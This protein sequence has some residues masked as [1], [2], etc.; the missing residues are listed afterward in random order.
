[1]PIDF[2]EI[3]NWRQFEDLVCDL[4]E[5]EG[6]H[7]EERAGI[8][9]DEGRDILAVGYFTNSL[10][11][12]ER[13]YLVSCKHWKGPVP[14]SEVTDIKDKMIQHEANGYLLVTYDIRSGLQHKIDG[15]KRELTIKYWLKRDIENLLIIHKDVFKK[16]LPK[17]YTQFFG[18]EGLIPESELIEL[19]NKKYGRNPNTDELI[20]WRKDTL[21]YSLTNLHEI[22][23]ILD[24]KDVL[25]S[26]NEM[27]E[28]LLAR[29]VDPMGHLTWGYLLH[30]SK[31]EETK[32][33][34]EYNIRHLVEFLNRARLIYTAHGLPRTEIHFESITQSFFQW[35][36]YHILWSKGILRVDPKAFPPY[37]EMESPQDNV[38]A[39]QWSLGIQLLNKKVIV[40]DVSRDNFF[41]VFLLVRAN[42][43]KPY[44]IKYGYS[45]GQPKKVRDA[46]IDYAEFFLGAEFALNAHPPQTLETNFENDLN[47]LYNVKVSSVLSLHFRVRGK[48]K[49]SRI[50]LAEAP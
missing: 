39:I 36:P 30:V 24:D 12:M 41:E 42:D 3:E 4:L 26:L 48:A 29:K 11:R 18:L 45:A 13:R 37:I 27:Y 10:E 21:N 31:T 50:L 43:G 44:F 17:S 28:K 40:L 32:K 46:G 16:H 9:P 2:S 15:L 23:A 25:D 35:R 19:F 14:E 20:S 7:I 38:F 22:E 6:F 49:I 33:E 8:G 47:K 5:K 34:I 1:M